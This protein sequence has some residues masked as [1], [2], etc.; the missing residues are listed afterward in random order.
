MMRKEVAFQPGKFTPVVEVSQRDSGLPAPAETSFKGLEEVSKT[1][2]LVGTAA[3]KGKGGL[4]TDP[5]PATAIALIIGS[6]LTV[7][8]CCE[9]FLHLGIHTRV[10]TPATKPNGEFLEPIIR[11]Y[12]Y[13]G[14]FVYDGKT[15]VT[16]AIEK[17]L[18]RGLFDLAVYATQDVAEG[19]KWT[20]AITPTTYADIDLDFYHL[21]ESGEISFGKQYPLKEYLERLV[22]YVVQNDNIATIDERL[23]LLAQILE[24]A[25][26]DS[27]KRFLRYART[28]NGWT[29]PDRSSGD[30]PTDKHKA[31]MKKLF[32][33]EYSSTGDVIPN[34]SFVS[35]VNRAYA[36]FRR[37][38]IE[39]SYAMKTIRFP[40]YEGGSASQ[41][42]TS[43]D[44]VLYST[45]P[46]SLADSTAALAFTTSYGCV[47]RL[48]S[49]PG[50]ERD[51]LLRELVSQSLY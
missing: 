45:I 49:A 27:L 12:Q 3:A 20:N 51:E 1:T 43:I 22:S 35:A 28:L 21:N 34:A 46:L 38:S 29:T 41:L 36:T 23:P 8:N 11:A 2:L 31:A 37:V 7:R 18:I 14:H 30:I 10:S 33:K 42:A 32:G 4:V 24:I 9:Q 15:Y 19:T 13:Y 48:H 25:T 39:R 44:D 5:T 26:E 6:L 16:R 50:Y 40:K 17:F 47:Q